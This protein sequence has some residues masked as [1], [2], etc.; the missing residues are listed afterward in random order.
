M[1]YL[2]LFYFTHAKL[3]DYYNTLYTILICKILG[4]GCWLWR[5]LKL[6]LYK[7]NI[8]L[9][10]RVGG[11]PECSQSAFTAETE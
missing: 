11:H 9:G 8:W 5:M 3:V 2:N 4:Y 7:K 10:L 1:D 6:I